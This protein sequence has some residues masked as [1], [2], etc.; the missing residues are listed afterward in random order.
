GA[1]GRKAS[2][3]SE[4]TLT[5]DNSNGLLPI[6]SQEVQIGRR[7][8]RNGDAEY[9][10]NRAPARLRDVRELFMGTG[11]GS[12][13]YSIIEQGRV[14]Q[15]LQ[16]NATA[17]RAVFEEAAGISLY[18]SRKTDAVRRLQRVDQNLQRLT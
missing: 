17:R 5:F 10:I 18:K 14:D 6:D 3:F 11:A 8:W 13:A 7:L 15:I 9:L 2:S 4:A 12:A 16:A 1:V